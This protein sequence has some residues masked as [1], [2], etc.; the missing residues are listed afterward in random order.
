MTLDEVDTPALLVDYG[1]L[2]RNLVRWQRFCDD[3]DLRC[4]PHV[5]THKCVEIARRQ[6]ELGAVGLVCQKLGEAEVMVDAGASNILVPYSLV[7]QAKLDR[8]AALA[9]RATVS[10]TVD[11]E[12]LL[13]GLARVAA[14]TDKQLSVLV[15]CDTGH[16]R[17]GVQSPHAAAELAASIERSSG[18]AFEGFL[19][20]PASPSC[21]AFLTNAVGE[22]RRRGLDPRTVSVGGTPMMWRADEFQPP[23]T[24]Y[25]AGNYAFLDRSSVAAGA[26]T[27]DDWA[28][29]VLT[30]VVSRPTPSR[31]IIDAGSKCLSNDPGPDALF[32][33]IFEA[34]HCRVI[35][36]DE[37]HGYIS[38]VDPDSLKLGRRVRVVPNHACAA[39]NLFDHFTVVSGETVVG[40]WPVAARG[41]SD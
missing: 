31:A 35:G 3:H 30:T 1:R 21:V 37:E 33:E 29:T 15:E 13:D 19:T 20:H 9:D 22:A 36:L 6:L 14:S 12:A 26:G 11:D 16:G 5:K 34:P 41:R 23:I 38:L 25:R 40:T 2:E 28:L 18:L 8:L 27:P 7:G 39:A 32:G 24:E 4:R 10:V 17:A